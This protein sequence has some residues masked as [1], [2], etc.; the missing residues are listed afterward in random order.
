MKILN[1]YAGIGG[2]RKLWGD[3]HE[4]TAVEIDP[5]I[6]A[7]YQD[8]FPNDEVVVGDAHAYLL[9]HFRE[10]DFIWSSPPCPT[11]SKLRNSWP[12][13][14]VYPSMMLYEEIL[15]LKYW[16]KGKWVV[17]NVISYYDPL[18]KPYEYK[19]HYYWANFVIDGEKG[20]SRGM[21]VKGAKRETLA[22]HAKKIGFDLSGYSGID[23]MKT[24]R[25]CVEPEAALFVFES[26][27]SKKQEV[28]F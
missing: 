26:A 18:I 14:V 19:K 4:I 25:N 9:E 15:L 28:L 8:F 2:N 6:A 22:R 11:H 7:I 10:F 5:K 1:L 12:D 23:K 20:G 3:E 27:F 13:K 17:E 24:L 16:F 21:G